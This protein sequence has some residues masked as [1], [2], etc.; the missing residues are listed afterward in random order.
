MEPVT[1]AGALIGTTVNKLLPETVLVLSMVALLAMTA[2]TTFRI[3]GRLRRAETLSLI[4]RGRITASNSS[5]R[6][7]ELVTLVEKVGNEASSQDD[8]FELEADSS[9]LVREQNDHGSDCSRDEGIAAGK[10]C[11]G[12]KQTEIGIPGGDALTVSVEKA[13][14]KTRLPNENL[15]F[16][17]HTPWF[18]VCVLGA[19]FVVVVALNLLKGGGAYRSPVGIE[20]GSPAFWS[21]NLLI[22]LWIAAVVAFVRR[23][24]MRRHEAKV[25]RGYA[26]VDG[27][28]AW[29]S[30]STVT[31]PLLCGVAGFCSG[32]FGIGG[33]I[34]A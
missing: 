1:I 28:V 26:F 23:H 7:S 27:D 31:Y 34:G 8:E 32:M 13:D 21:V 5:L 18:N 22:L 6:P 33:G 12:A 4:A 14:C 30:R 16:D 24:L 20:C 25:A 3:A 11:P 17:R 2:R 9:A 29:D 15:E 19:L 10:P